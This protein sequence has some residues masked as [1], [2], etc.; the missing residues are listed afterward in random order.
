MRIGELAHRVGTTAHS[1][2]YYERRGLLPSTGRRDNGYRDY[3]EAGAERLRLLVGLRQLDLPLDQ[4]ADIATLC[5]ADRCD[6]VSAELR[7]IIR[8][9]RRDLVS[10]ID[11]LAYLDQRLADLDGQL[12][13]GQSPRTLITVER[14]N[15]MIARCDDGCECGCE[16]CRRK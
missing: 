15:A 10:Q 9:K 14:R 1:I 6:E 11:A 12:D 16:C 8:D 4:A 7:A 3:D 5:V 2:R 13:A